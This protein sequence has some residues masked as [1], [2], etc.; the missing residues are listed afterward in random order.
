VS[1][2]ELDTENVKR[3]S[4]KQKID[5]QRKEAM[6]V[7]KYADFQK[8]AEAKA[9]KE[10]DVQQKAEAKA[11]KKVNIPTEIVYQQEDAA[12]QKLNF[13]K[14]VDATKKKQMLQKV[15]A[16]KEANDDFVT[17]TFDSEL[18]VKGEDVHTYNDMYDSTTTSVYMMAGLW[19]GHKAKSHKHRIIRA[20]LNGID[21]PAIRV[22]DW[23]DKL[24]IHA[25]KLKYTDLFNLDD[26]NYDDYI[27]AVI[28]IAIKINLIVRYFDKSP[29]ILEPTSYEVQLEFCKNTPNLETKCILRLDDLLG[30]EELTIK[31][32]KEYKIFFSKSSA[33]K[34]C[35]DADDENSVE[36]ECMDISS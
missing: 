18:L 24:A 21:Y 15:D 11:K 2:N 3:C 25:L 16:T 26:S 33:E 30:C 10:A 4:K 34:E 13:T 17:T 12:Q 1:E 5:I 23:I 27:T 28:M 7:K 6:A 9:K 31:F 14:K 19:K 32:P 8:K 20:R 36:K 22:C 29:A 35:A